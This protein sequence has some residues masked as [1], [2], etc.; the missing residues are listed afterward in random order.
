LL[1]ESGMSEPAAESA[2]PLP[3][4]AKAKGGALGKIIP[5]LLV[6]NL[7]ATGFIVFKTLTGSP[8]AAAAATPPAEKKEEKASPTAA[9]KGPIATLDPFVANLDEPGPPRYI[10]MTLELELTSEEAMKTLEDSKQPVR[11]Q[12]LGYLSGL[13]AADTLGEANKQKIR[14]GLLARVTAAVGKGQVRRMFF[15]EF[16][17]Q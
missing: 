13:K 3:A 2:A 17:V 10:K 11:D 7:G 5:V 9:V 15:S 4:A 16:V 14:D 12:V 8:A 6:M 1:K